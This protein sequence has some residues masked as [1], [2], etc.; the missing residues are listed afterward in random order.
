MT[1][2]LRA[3]GMVSIIMFAVSSMLSAGL[4]FTLRE[5]IA[6]LREPHRIVRV[7]LGN[8]V[9]VPLLAVGI[10]HAFAL[11]PALALGFILLGTAAGAPF[12]IKLVAVARADIALGTALLV[13]LV[14]VTVVFM[15][16][17]VPLLA[18][19]AAVDV[20]EMALTL[21]LTL[22]LPLAVGLLAKQRAARWARWVQPLART[23]STTCLVLLLAT[24]LVRNVRG[25]VDIL[26]SRAA[27]AILL[28][29][30]GSFVIGYLI[31]SPHPERR[32]VLGLGTAQ[33]NIA[34]S[35]VVAAE[36]FRGPDTL[37]LVVVA[38]TL[39]LLL[40]IPVARWLRGWLRIS[41][42]ESQ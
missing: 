30:L 4:S 35:I 22:L 26:S 20:T 29:V 1:E 25:L 36:G 31:A 39:T 34:A 28:F 16:F 19:D 12:L 23:A 13:L 27:L 33:R 38:S 5:V 11:D 2:V 6:P 9:L 3:I 32:A 7:L 42:D 15:S 41:R 8:F 24:T 21:G 18:P 14:P 40:L 10:V 37:V 17:A